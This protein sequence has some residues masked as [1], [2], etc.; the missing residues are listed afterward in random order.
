MTIDI[1]VNNQISTPTKVVVGNKKDPDYPSDRTLEQSLLGAIL[2]KGQSPSADTSALMKSIGGLDYRDFYF[3]QN[4]TIY[5][6][7]Q[8]IA[9]DGQHVDLTTLRTRLESVKN[10]ARSVLDYVGGDSYLN[11]LIASVKGLSVQ[12]YADALMRL[13]VRRGFMYL[14]QHALSILDDSQRDLPSALA[15]IRSAERQLQMRL[16]SMSGQSLYDAVDTVQKRIEQ[17]KAEIADP[18]FKPGITTGLKAMDEA[19]LGWQRGRLY[20]FSA[21]Q[22]WGKTVV[23]MNWALNAAMAGYRVLYVTLEMD[24]NEFIDRLICNLGRIDYTHYQ[25]RDFQ[26][27]ELERLAEAQQRV[28]TLVGS[29]QFTI[30]RKVSPTLDELES[31]IYSAFYNP[32]FDILFLDYAKTTKFAGGTDTPSEMAAMFTR[33][34]KWSKKDFAHAPLICATQMNRN[35]EGRSEDDKFN[36]NDLFGTSAAQ[37]NADGVLFLWR[38]SK[39]QKNKGYGDPHEAELIIAKGRNVD[40]HDDILFRIDTSYMKIFDADE[41]A[42][43]GI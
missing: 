24:P 27:D 11:T 26:G 38:P 7:M 22:G 43:S 14:S 5:K 10:G 4:G 17:V 3:V 31:E 6:A 20:I 21:P 13:S 12:S 16:D 25:K 1:W 32:G 41:Y 40:T 33:I 2:L 18:S 15:E 36:M 34:D 39:L 42:G 28:A 35:Y 9:R 23:M 8:A 30:L 29:G 19:L 37:D